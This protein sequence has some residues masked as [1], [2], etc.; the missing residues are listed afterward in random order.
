[1]SS[2]FLF[3]F[4][5]FSCFY[6]HCSKGNNDSFKSVGGFFRFLFLF[7]RIMASHFHAWCR[8][9]GNNLE[10]S[11]DSGSNAMPYRSLRRLPIFSRCVLVYSSLNTCTRLHR[12]SSARSWWPR[13]RLEALFVEDHLAIRDSLVPIWFLRLGSRRPDI[14]NEEFHR[15]QR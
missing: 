7:H 4:S 14:S 1:M 3:L 15:Q 2:F 11:W 9:L 6:K 5:S 12:L 8:P 10:Q 13:Y